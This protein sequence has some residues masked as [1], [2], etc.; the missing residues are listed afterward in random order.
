VRV[1]IFEETH[2]GREM[3]RLSKINKYRM[4]NNYVF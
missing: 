3:R 4:D 2:K 1:L